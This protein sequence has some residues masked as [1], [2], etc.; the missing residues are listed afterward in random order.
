MT[1]HQT[2]AYDSPA[3]RRLRR[4]APLLLLGGLLALALAPGII[5]G[6]RPFQTG[7][8]GALEQ[9]PGAC[10]QL[11]RAAM[12][13]LEVELARPEANWLTRSHF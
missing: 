1:L 10:A 6:D 8:C 13:E 7:L 11:G 3:S 9:T 2:L 5:A 4:Y 12:L